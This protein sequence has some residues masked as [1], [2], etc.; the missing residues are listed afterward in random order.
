M[1]AGSTRQPRMSLDITATRQRRRQPG[2]LIDV[3]RHR[4]VRWLEPG[5]AVTPGELESTESAQDTP[6]GKG[7]ILL[8][9]TEHHRR[10]R[11]ASAT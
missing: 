5:E 3:P 2:V 9:R 4:G 7:D 1:P 6:L 10:R 11:S 8:L